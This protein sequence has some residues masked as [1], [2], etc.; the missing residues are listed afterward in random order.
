M[1]TL[2]RGGQV[3]GPQPLGRRDILTAGRTVLAVS[4]PGEIGL[5]GLE[6]R[7]ID[8]SD[9]LVVPGFV[10]SHVHILGG[11]G[12]GGPSTRCPEI[13][14]AEIV[15]AGVTS[16]IGCLGTDAV[17]RHMASLL[18]KARALETEGI[19][20]WI[21]V[22]S[23][24]LPVVTLTGS[25]RSDLALI[26]KVVGA[27]EIAVSDHRSAQPTFAELAG[28]AAECRVGGMLGG[29]A[30]V[31]HLHVGDG[32]AGLQPL[33]RLRDET[34]IPVGQ[35][36]PTHCNRHPDLLEQAIDWMLS[37]GVADL[38]AGLGSPS[39]DG[40]DVS[41]PDAV[42]RC[43]ARRVPPGR[44]T[45]SSDGQGSIPSFDDQGRLTG[46]AV[47]SQRTLLDTFRTLVRGEVVPLA[48]ACRI[49]STNPA[50]V[51]RLAGKGEIRAGADADLLLLDQDLELRE[52][53]T[54]GR[55]T[56]KDGEPIIHGTF[57]RD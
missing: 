35:I 32:P 39:H 20:T 45:V 54:L 5:T 22:G 15:A 36:V 47:A 28:L 27:G 17:T 34:E 33:F 57:A 1:T 9:R 7:E 31:L 8:A 16:L 46:L 2:I 29:K 37:G 50:A 55:A 24:E 26:D 25:V 4:P 41:V 13:E 19:S 23:Y 43:V 53:F 6:V 10:D 40:R 52:S 14:V 56:M 12:E 3:Y 42:R 48:D 49:F 11:G 18:A 44:I 51:Y 21:F 30:G 38:T